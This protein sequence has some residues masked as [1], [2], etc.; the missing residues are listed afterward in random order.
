MR[1]ISYKVYRGPRAGYRCNGCNGWFE[2]VYRYVCTPLHDPAILAA[3]ETEWARLRGTH[4]LL[5]TRF[6]E[7]LK[8]LPKRVSDLLIH[9]NRK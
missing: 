6:P 8:P 3:S 5:G 2:Q 9:D 7:Q 1:F 4:L